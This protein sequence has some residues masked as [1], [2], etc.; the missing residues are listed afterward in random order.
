MKSFRQFS[1]DINTILSR[2]NND[3]PAEYVIHLTNFFGLPDELTKMR[4]V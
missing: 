3:E 2:W 1:N 4:A